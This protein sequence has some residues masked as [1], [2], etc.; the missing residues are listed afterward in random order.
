LRA[1]RLFHRVRLH[2]ETIDRKVSFDPLKHHP[3][4][5]SHPIRPDP[6]EGYGKW[7]KERKKGIANIQAKRSPMLRSMSSFPDLTS[8]ILAIYTSFLPLNSKDAY[9][10]LETLHR[11]RLTRDRPKWS[12]GRFPHDPWERLVEDRPTTQL[13]WGVCRG[14]KCKTVK[15]RRV[16]Q[17]RSI[18]EDQ[19]SG[20]SGESSCEVALRVVG[21]SNRATTEFVSH[22]SFNSVSLLISCKPLLPN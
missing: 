10:R 18:F 21:P 8:A 2:D 20:C 7:G 15:G 3:S 9:N 4:V 16:V 17:D 13:G 22:N 1:Q 12:Q 14:R 19:G 5:I 6:D 11:A